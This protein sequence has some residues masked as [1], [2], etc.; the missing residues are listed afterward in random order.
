MGEETRTV[1]KRVWKD[2]LFARVPV[3]ET[4]VVKKDKPEKARDAANFI[5]MIR[6]KRFELI[7]GMGDYYPEGKAM[8]AALKEMN[9]LEENYLTL[10]TGK[11]MTDTVR[12]TIGWSPQ[13]EN[14]REPE[15]L[16]RFS[17]EN[18]ILKADSNKGKPIWL[19]IEALDNPK[20]I[21]QA[22]QSQLPSSGPS[23]FHYRVPVRSV[24]KLKYGDKLMAKKFL[25]VH[26]YG[27][28][29]RIPPQFLEDSRII[30]F[31]PSK[32]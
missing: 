17:E 13:K 3:E 28:V 9:R 19:E 12:F 32:E 23:H 22:I 25:K 21:H 30:E 24:I 2:S 7:S 14:L 31:F 15:M 10:F 16:F 5:F 1:Y 20:K 8:E 18:G 27:P 29:L 26:Q 4:E 11:Q 6:E